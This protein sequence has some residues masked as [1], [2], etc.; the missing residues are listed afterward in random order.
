MG[1][2]QMTQGGRQM[3]YSLVKRTL[4]MLFGLSIVLVA[5]YAHAADV[6]GTWVGGTL[7]GATTLTLVMK[8]TG[9]LVTGTIMGVGTADGPI[10]GTVDGNTIRIRFDAGYDDTPLLNVNGDEIT[11]LLSGTE[12]TLR[13]VRNAS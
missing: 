6:S 1:G 3:T 13:R 7:R 11:G 10:K 2:R 4:L 12:I 5:G 9:N 8:Q